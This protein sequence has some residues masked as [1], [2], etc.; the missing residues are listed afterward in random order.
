MV[1][2]KTGSVLLSFVVGRARARV[3]ELFGTHER[4]SPRPSFFIPPV[5]LYHFRFDKPWVMRL[6]GS[7]RAPLEPTRGGEGKSE[8]QSTQRGVIEFEQHK[9]EQT[10]P[11][12]PRR[13]Y[14]HSTAEDDVGMVG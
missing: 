4:G 8:G 12:G 13:D 7:A 6:I 2:G 9:R 11:I 10:A 5:L 1:D 14:Q 3:P